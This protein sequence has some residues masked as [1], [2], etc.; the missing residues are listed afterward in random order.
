MNPR[1]L[2]IKTFY[3]PSDSGL[4]SASGS[5]K[6]SEFNG[7][8]DTGIET[9]YDTKPPLATMPGTSPVSYMFRHAKDLP[10]LSDE[11]H[12]MIE[13]REHVIRP[14]NSFEPVKFEQP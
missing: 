12:I 6:K 7:F 9:Y 11:G 4:G 13:K 14:L 5:R 1:D 3:S 10:L 8:P 2:Y